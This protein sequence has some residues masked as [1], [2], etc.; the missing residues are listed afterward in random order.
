MPLPSSPH[1]LLF[2]LISHLGWGICWRSH[3][4]EDDE[5]VNAMCDEWDVPPSAPKPGRYAPCEPPPRA[6]ILPAIVKEFCM[7]CNAEYSRRL[8]PILE[9]L[10]VVTRL[11]P[12]LEDDQEL[13]W[14]L[15]TLMLI[16]QDYTQQLRRALNDLA[17]ATPGEEGA[18]E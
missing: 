17:T 8:S 3:E 14:T 5:R 9:K 7:S 2:S 13:A 10:E 1:M 11:A 6:V 15:S 16:A 12:V 4:R 18:H